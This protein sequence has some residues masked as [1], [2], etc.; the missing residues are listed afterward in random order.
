MEY[1]NK[2]SQI[3]FEGVEDENEKGGEMSLEGS[4]LMKYE[5]V[6]YVRKRE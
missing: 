3:G 5:E 6:V 4:G 2:N 1:I